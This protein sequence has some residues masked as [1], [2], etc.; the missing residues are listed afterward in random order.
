M[1]MAFVLLCTSVVP[2]FVQSKEDS[3]ASAASLIM[4]DNIRKSSDLVILTGSSVNLR[5]AASTSS[6]VLYKL[7]KG[8]SF[9]YRGETS[10]FY[11]VYDYKRKLTGYVSKDYAAHCKGVTLNSFGYFHIEGSNVNV[12]K[13][14]LLKAAVVCTLQKGATVQQTKRNGRYDIVYSQGYYWIETCGGWMAIAERP[15]N[16]SDR[17]KEAM[18]VYCVS[19]IYSNSSYGFS[20]SNHDCNS[21][22]SANARKL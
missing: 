17:F 14:P 21:Y 3:T 11:K 18:G 22:L 2:G 20:Y 8:S 4:T 5:K 13:V 19:W 16:R 1:I 12:R 7:H 15:D 10:K 9:E 6:T